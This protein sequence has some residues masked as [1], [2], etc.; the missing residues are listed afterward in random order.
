MLS[1][2]LPTEAATSNTD[3]STQ[4]PFLTHGS[5]YQNLALSKHEGMDALEC[6]PTPGSLPVPQT[7]PSTSEGVPR[8]CS[9]A[10]GLLRAA[11]E[12]SIKQTEKQDFLSIRVLTAD[13]RFCPNATV[14]SRAKYCSSQRGQTTRS[15]R[16]K[17]K[18]S[19]GRQSGSLGIN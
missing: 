18:Q 4:A 8:E 11:T 5:I 15:P 10:L 13:L 17:P 9:E 2:R 19:A 14:R 1:A 7:G 12:D 16:E 6:G 3:S